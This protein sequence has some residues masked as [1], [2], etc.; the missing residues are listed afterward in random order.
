V[1]RKTNNADLAKH[2]QKLKKKNPILVVRRV[3]DHKGRHTTTQVDLKNRKLATFL[4]G[5]YEGIDGVDVS[6]NPPWVGGFAA[7]A[8]E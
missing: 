4:Q 1:Y 3:F 8:T 6:R 7:M 5:I 2:N